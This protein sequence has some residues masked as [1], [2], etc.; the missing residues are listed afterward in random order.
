M[1]KREF[2]FVSVIFLILVSQLGVAQ[3]TFEKEVIHDVVVKELSQPATFLIKVKNLANKTDFFEFYTFVDVMLS[4]R[5]STIIPAGS[6][7]Q[8]V[9]GIYPSEKLRDERKGGYT[10]VYYMKTAEDVKEDRLVIRILPLIEVLKVDFPKVITPDTDYVTL[11]I[12]N[13]ENIAL[14]DMVVRVESAFIDDSKKISFEPFQ[15]QNLTIVMDRDKLKSMLAGKYLVKISFIADSKT[16]VDIIKEVEIIEKSN[17]VTREENFGTLFY[18][19]IRIIKIN[20]G[21]TISDVEVIIKKNVFANAFTTFSLQADEAKKSAT[22][23]TFIWYTTLKPGESFSVEVRTNYMLPL[24]ILFGVILIV[25]LLMFWFKTSLVIRKK[26]VRVRSKTGEFA[27]KIILLIKSRENLNNIFIRDKLPKLAELHERYGTIRPSKIDRE[28]K[29]LEWHIP[30]L[31]K[32]EE[33]IISYIIYSKV[34]VLGKFEIPRATA[35]FENMKGEEKKSASNSILFFSEEK[36][37]M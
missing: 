8:V 4:P 20:E 11:E 13:Q 7:K 23:Y 15:K 31:K 1:K 24:A 28:R 27:I 33:Q 30:H 16:K 2:I 14:K 19:A 32:G 35:R 5:G 34:A 21:N 17:V 18:P 6:E 12:E 37:P 36:V 3:L 22:Y 9:L 29:I 10:F 25:L 26:A